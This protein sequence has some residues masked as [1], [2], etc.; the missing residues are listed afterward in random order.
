VSYLFSE[1]AALKSFLQGFTVSDEK[2]TNRPVQVW[3]VTPD[4]EFRAQTFPFITLELIDSVPATYRQHS[5]VVVDNDRQ[6]T[7][8]PVANRA[9]T[10]EIPIA[11]DLTYQIT[12]YARHPRHDRLLIANLL[13]KAFPGKRGYLPVLNDLGTERSYRHMFL[14]EFTKRDTVEDGRR[15]YRNVFTVSVTSE[16]SASQ[17]P[18]VREVG[19]VLINDTI[20]NIPADKQ[21]V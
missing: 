9:Y 2:V 3:Y 10:Y 21:I 1:D 18:S 14:D 4:L 7:V 11:W 12:T 19:T 13:N 8:A 15:L 20:E 5:G 17:A 6:G 16:G